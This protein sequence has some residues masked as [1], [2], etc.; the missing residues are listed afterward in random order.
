MAYERELWLS[1]VHRVAGV[2]EV[3]R[4]ALAG[5][6]AAAAVVLPGIPRAWYA[7]VNDSKLLTVAARE[8]LAPLILAEAAVGLAMV[9]SETIDAKGIVPATRRAMLQAVRALGP[10]VDALLVD[11]LSLPEARLPYRALVHGDRLSLSIA[12]ASIVAKV[13]RD[14]LM[15]ELD[16]QYPGYGLSRNKGYGTPAHLEALARLGPSPIHRRSFLPG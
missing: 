5:P 1:G 8:R 14:R 10:S 3:G 11:A 13:V 7:H 15:E 16:G 4:G 6:V 12:S 9:P 2:D